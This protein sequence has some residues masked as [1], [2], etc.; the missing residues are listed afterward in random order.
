MMK[1]NEIRLSASVTLVGAG[2]LSVAGA[3]LGSVSNLAWYHAF[4]YVPLTIAL[5][6]VAAMVLRHPIMLGLYGLVATAT[7]VAGAL[8]LWEAGIGGGDLVPEASMRIVTLTLLVGAPLVLLSSLLTLRRHSDT[9]M[10]VALAAALPLM[11]VF[12]TSAVA[13]WSVSGWLLVIA[14]IACAVGLRGRRT[15]DSLTQP[16][17]WVAA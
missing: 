14:G 13:G 9:V 1:L 10:Y 17:P 8:A 16:Q 4:S 2:M 5:C 11:D 6:L 3:P 15:A 12:S 7:G